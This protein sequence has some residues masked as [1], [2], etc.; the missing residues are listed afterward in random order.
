MIP[1]E[2]DIEVPEGWRR[3]VFAEHQKEYLPLPA[4]FENA[5][6]GHLI[7]KW[8]LT[9]RERIKILFNGN[10][11]FMTLTFHKPLQPI[12]LSLDTPK[13]EQPS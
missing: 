1:I 7:T 9:W 3:V 5:P 12:S 2:P 10:L 13:F 8:Q 11:W 6:T 4:I